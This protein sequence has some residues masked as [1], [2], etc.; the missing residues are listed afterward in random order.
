MVLIL[1][2]FIISF[3]ILNIKF[4]NFNL[5]LKIPCL[6]IHFKYHCLSGRLDVS[7]V[8][9]SPQGSRCDQ[10]KRRPP[11]VDY[12]AYVGD[13]L[14]LSCRVNAPNI[15]TMI[16]IGGTSRGDIPL[17]PVLPSAEGNYLCNATNDCGTSTD[18]LNL[19]VYG[20]K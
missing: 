13:S 8:G 16:Y 19:R 4:K 10:L 18:M 14:T 3:F 2:D 6:N 5:N 20:K 1:L 17:T 12:C 7:L 11:G 9:I 15:T